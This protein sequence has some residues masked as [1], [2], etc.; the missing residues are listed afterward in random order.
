MPTANVAPETLPSFAE[1]VDHVRNQ[2][3]EGLDQLYRVF[4]T[5]SGSLRRQIGF[6]EFDD[7][8]HDVFLLVV[9]AI[10]EG[11]LREPAALP[12]YI[13][14]VARL[15]TCSSIGVRARHQRLSGSL[16]RWTEERTGYHTP[17]EQLAQKQRLQIMRDLLGELS[18]RE[19]EVL[20]RFY[21][22]EQ[23]KEQ[24][25]REMQMT[26]TQFRLTKSRAKQR[27]GRIGAEHLGRESGMPETAVPASRISVAQR[28][29][30]GRP[31]ALSQ[32]AAA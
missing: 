15:S 7:R 25:C 17:E 22:F 31:P 23:G 5:L 32:V 10:R 19:R 24:I 8:M 1:V 9:E 29:G 4:R 11:K 12:S 6:R 26:E 21:L 14:G 3:P 20:T 2:H 30:A 28:A 27:L 18:D 16:R 13:H